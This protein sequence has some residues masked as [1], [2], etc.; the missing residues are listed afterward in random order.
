[1]SGA[2]T[3]AYDPQWAARLVPLTGLANQAMS[4][5]MLPDPWG[6][7]Y[8]YSASSANG[9]SQYFLAAYPAAKPEYCVLVVGA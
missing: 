7:L 1:M 6:L 3:M 9:G 2:A 8:Q 5:L 4:N